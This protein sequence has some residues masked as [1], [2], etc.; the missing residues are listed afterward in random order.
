MT[1]HPATFHDH[2]LTRARP[3]LVDFEPILDPFA[4]IGKIHSLGLHSYGLEIEPEWANAHPRTTRG[5]ALELPFPDSSFRAIFTSPCYGNRMADH[6]NARDP[7]KRVGYKFA[8]GRDPD[9]KSSSTLY[10]GELYRQFHLAAWAESTRVLAP[11]GRFVLNIKNH[12]KDGV[13]QRVSEWHLGVL[14]R[15]GLHLR[16]VE[17]ILTPGMRHGANSAL[18]VEY[19]YLFILDK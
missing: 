13:E 11:G 10:W 9:P 6:H 15:L 4:G 19:E 1:K 5:N 7:S 14:V 8:L 18:R 16:K 17:R 3:Y 12:I 2:I